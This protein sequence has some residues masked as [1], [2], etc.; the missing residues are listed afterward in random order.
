M[1]KPKGTPQGV[2]AVAKRKKLVLG[3]GLDALIPDLQP[4][5]GSSSAYRRCAVDQIRPNRYQPRI[6]FAEEELAELADS[7]RSQGIIQPL[8]VRQDE[9]GFELVAGERRLRAARMAGLTEVPVVVREVPDAQMLEFSIVE[10]IQRENLNP[11]EEAE[12]YHRLMAAFDL[13]QDQVAARV[14]KSRSAVANILRLRQLPEDI[15]ASITGGE[16]AMGHARAL[17]GAENAAVQR[18]AWRKTVA[19]RLSVRQTEALVKRLNAAKD[20]PSALPD[21]AG[22]YFRGVSEDL[23][24]HFGTKVEIRHRGEKG[25]VE[26]AFYSLDDLDQ[27]LGR[28][29]G[30]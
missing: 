3:R 26:I 8:L 16:I 23:S 5:A 2:A 25:K 1:A 22:S 10:N 17:L 15:K 14:G 11:M 13:T 18:A 30:R 6:R 4:A 9:H 12:A 29:K 28:L 7:I 19:E 24:R 27:L 20:R 21:A